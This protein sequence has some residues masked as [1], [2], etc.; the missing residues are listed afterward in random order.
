MSGHNRWSKIK[1]KK[2][3]SDS[4]RSKVWT[5]VIKEI[6]ISARLGGGDI[7]GN[8]RLRAAVEKGRAVNMPN[9]TIERSIKKGT[10][11]LEGVT[12]EEFNYEV[13]GPGGT[14][15]LVEIMTDNRN[16]TASEIRN[17]ISRGNG[18]LGASGS[19]HW[20]FKKQ[21]MIVF[22]KSAVD[23]N[24]LTDQAI[25]LGAED[26]LTQGEALIVVT[27]PKEFERIRE[28]L[29]RTKVAGGKMPEPVS[30]EVTM[31]PQNV[32]RL[33][34]KDAEGAVKLVN[35]LEDH[36]DVQNVYSNMDVDESVLEGAG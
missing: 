13:F 29:K 32:V 18:N 7:S 17:L 27:E 34:G 10:G 15:L 1:H 31:V 25:E 35:M 14:A 12:Y 19:V 20:M 33:H 26:I 5:K 36:D 2:E 16:R 9:D 23:E 11:D 28:G 4:K 24:A 30:A 3:A 8:P 21:G 6:T 22:E